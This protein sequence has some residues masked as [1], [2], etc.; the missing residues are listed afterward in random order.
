M[1]RY[2][3]SNDIFDYQ[4]PDFECFYLKNKPSE[5]QGELSELIHFYY[6]I[7]GNIHYEIFG[8]GT[9]VNGFKASVIS[10]NGKGFCLKKSILFVAIARLL[11]FPSRLKC[12]HVKKPF[13]VRRCIGTH[14][15]KRFST[16]VY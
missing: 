8:V 4:S 2:L 10:Q 7:R 15:G 5:S 6:L 11:G 3:I 1:D 16:L 12:G 9:S 14:G 13:S